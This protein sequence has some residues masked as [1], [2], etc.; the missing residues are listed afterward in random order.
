MFKCD[1]YLFLFLDIFWRRQQM[2]VYTYVKIVLN[3]FLL[4]KHLH[5]FTQFC[6]RTMFIYIFYCLDF[7]FTLNKHSYQFF[8]AKC[9]SKILLWIFM[10]IFHFK[11]FYCIIFVG[12]FLSVLS[13]DEECTSFIKRKTRYVKFRKDSRPESAANF[14][15]CNRQRGHGC[16]MLS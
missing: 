11:I 13:H 9:K 15:N 4:V 6:S 12:E 7:H 1:I 5:T 14:E 10:N 16:N 3:I 8:Y 2:F